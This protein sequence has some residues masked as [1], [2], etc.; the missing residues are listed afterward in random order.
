[1]LV[2]KAIGYV[3]CLDSK[4]FST[5]DLNVAKAETVTIF[6]LHVKPVSTLFFIC[7]IANTKRQ[8]NRKELER[9]L[10]IHQ[11]LPHFEILSQFKIKYDYHNFDCY[12]IAEKVFQLSCKLSTARILCLFVVILIET[13]FLVKTVQKLNQK[14]QAFLFFFIT[15]VHMRKVLK[16]AVMFSVNWK[17]L[18]E[19]SHLIY[20]K[21]KV[22]LNI[23][24]RCLKCKVF[25]FKTGGDVGFWFDWK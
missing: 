25:S 11:I 6:H 2:V 20:T 17:Q 23:A 8:W 19:K 10:K 14:V 9:W 16:Q 21:H 5:N 18:T 12:L 24:I 15:S 7:K 1:M 3:S 22:I 13:N 4:G